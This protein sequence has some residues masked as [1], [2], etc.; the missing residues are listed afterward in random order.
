MKVEEF[1]DPYVGQSWG[2]LGAR[3][4][5]SGNQISVT[6]GYPAAGLRD[7]LASQLAEFLGVDSVDL[8]LSFA[9]G[10]G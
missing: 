5:T 8:Q 2:S 7:T 1:I 6:L 9:P 3:I 10:G 4:L